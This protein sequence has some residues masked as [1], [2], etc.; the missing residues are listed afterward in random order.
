MEPRWKTALCWGT[1][2]TF[3]TMPMVVLFLIFISDFWPNIQNHIADIKVVGPFFQSVT[4][5]MFGLAGLRSLDKFVETKNGN[6][7]EPPK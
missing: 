6:H 7:K 1:V 5:L 2:L 3:F 4:G